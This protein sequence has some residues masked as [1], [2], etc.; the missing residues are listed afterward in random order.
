[1]KNRFWM[2]SSAVVFAVAV[3]ATS[4]NCLAGSGR[5]FT[6]GPPTWAMSHIASS[7]ALAQPAM[8]LHNNAAPSFTFHPMPVTTVPAG[9]GAGYSHMS[10]TAAAV[11]SVP[12]S[13]GTGYS[14]MSTTMPFTTVPTSG[15][16]GYSHMLT[17][18]VPVTTVPTSGAGF[19]H[20]GTTTTPVST[21][22]TGS[23]TGFSSMSTTTMPAS[24]GY[25]WSH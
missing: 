14:H 21:M 15:G 5:G 2:L 17:T 10:A 24:G 18:A 4:S 7:A 20:M 19:S 25:G 3:A 6:M 11:T 23:G 16:A 13:I 12:T 1:M 22:P 8:A 9:S